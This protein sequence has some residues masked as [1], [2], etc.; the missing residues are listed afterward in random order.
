MESFPPGPRGF[1]DVANEFRAFLRDPAGYAPR[2]QARWGPSVGMH[3][4]KEP[5]VFLGD[6][7]L[8][9]EV[10]LDK[11]GVFHKDKVTSGLSS[12]VG[13]GL[14]TSE[15]ELWRRQRKLIAPSLTK[16]HIASY[17]EAMTR[18]TEAWAGKPT[19]RTNLL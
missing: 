16:K 9:G 19:P 6:P 18:I 4:G 11:E 3:V 10:L 7:E 13:Q 8:V 17:A 5:L 12:F 2:A 1:V 14:L 15:D